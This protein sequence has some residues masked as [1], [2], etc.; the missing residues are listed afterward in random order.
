MDDQ[1]NIEGLYFCGVHLYN[2]GE[3][4]Q[5]DYNSNNKYFTYRKNEFKNIDYKDQNNNYINVLDNPVP[6]GVYTI[7]PDD[8]NNPKNPFLALDVIKYDQKGGLAIAYAN[9]LF[10]QNNNNYSA[11][12]S[13]MMNSDNDS[14]KYIY[15]NGKWYIFT[16]NNDVLCP[17]DGIV[18]YYCEVM[19]GVYRKNET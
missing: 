6:N 12:L 2:G 14:K 11:I 15:Y 10:K 19:K 9:S 18:N 16:N 13:N 1:V 17:V 7:D 4:S 5:S 8:Q 3:Y